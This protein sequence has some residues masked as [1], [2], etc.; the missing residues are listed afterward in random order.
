MANIYPGSRGRTINLRLP[1]NSDTMIEKE[2]KHIAYRLKQLKDK[3]NKAII[4]LGAGCSVSAGIPRASA[5]V[6]DV[7][8]KHQLNP[9]VAD[10]VGKDSI[11][12]AQLMGCLQ[13]QER[14]ELFAEYVS[15]ANVNVSHI[16]LAHLLQN[17]YV[18]Y[19]VTTNFDNLMLRALALHN[20][21]PP[22]YDLSNLQDLTTTTL[23][24]Q[25]IIYLHGQ[26]HGMWQ[27][28]TEEEM[29]RVVKGEARTAINIFSKIAN[30][31]PW[32]VIGYSG[33]DFIF[34]ALAAQGRFDNSLFW[35]GYKDDEPSARVQEKL[36]RKPNTQTFWIKGYDA[37]SFFIK[38]SAELNEAQ[39]LVFDKPFSFLEEVLQNIKEIDG[40][41]TYKTAKERLAQ[42]KQ[43]VADAIERYETVGADNATM[44]DIAIEKAQ[45]KKALIDC[46]LNDKYDELAVLEAK[47]IEL[48]Y[49]D[50]L[51][52]VA[53]VYYNWGIDLGKLADT[54]SG[55]EAEGLYREAFAKF[56]RTVEIKHDKHEAWLG[57]GTYLGKLAGIKS[58]TE[59]EGLYREA[60]A[61]FARAVQIK[62]DYH[63]ALYNWGNDLSS[64]A[65]TKNSLETEGLYREAFVK[66]ARAVEIK[67]DKHEA[68]NNWG[69]YL[70]SLADTKGGLEAE[71][72]YWEAFAKFAR[73][74]EIKPDKH[75]AWNNWGCY[76]GKLAA[77]K[78]GIEAEGLY[79]EAFA[80]YARAVEIKPDTNEVWYNWG[81]DL[82]QLW[83]HTGKAD[84]LLYNEAETKLSKY[85]QMGGGF[86]NLACLYALG[87][88]PD[89]AF[90]LLSQ[91]LDK[92]EISFGH[93]AKDK[94]WDGLRDAPEYIALKEKYGG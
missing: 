89:K 37:D 6:M 35:V 28:N 80:K 59:G 43:L 88:Q 66:Y 5:I 94:D 79:R 84:K 81:Y 52:D 17:G 38:L 40:D 26:H 19:I 73:S 22:V 41:E 45:L 65:G 75:G 42:S 11:N 18:D 87:S 68:W 30:G 46:L 36:L 27:L 14:K 8:E 86:Y 92:K 33:E 51:P 58:G 4:F 72:L 83:N 49:D 61:K 67:P 21:F 69:S 2:I 1:F 29:N 25:S 44:D 93:V 53:D 13:P 71:G 3:N 76:L 74:V 16:Y 31:R 82:M 63:E 24:T 47:V 20:I 62:P 54:K 48:G 23:D 7:L 56:A 15:K 55:V 64:L 60:F 9:D 34:D 91:C 12:Y 10:K 77:A 90:P 70:G 85:M 39:P 78:S 32:I 50:L 57:W